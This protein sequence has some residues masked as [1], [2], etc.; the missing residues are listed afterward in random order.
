MK[1]TQKFFG[2]LL[3]ALMVL[4][5]L[6]TTA[7]AANSADDDDMNMY[8]NS[9][10]IEKEQPELDEE[11]KQLISFYQ[12]NP[13]DENYFNLREK[14]IE[15]YNAVVERKE[16]KLNELKTETAGKPGGEEIVAEMEDLVQRTNKKI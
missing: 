4:I 3:A 7:M 12:K 11:T 9:D 2:V 14:V 16:T 10:F 1:F 13:T 6:S 15:D 8:Q 5:P